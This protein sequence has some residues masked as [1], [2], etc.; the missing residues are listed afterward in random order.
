MAQQSKIPKANVYKATALIK[1][2][3]I[4]ITSNRIELKS[5]DFIFLSCYN[6]WKTNEIKNIK[7]IQNIKGIAKIKDAINEHIQALFTWIKFYPELKYFELKTIDEIHKLNSI[8]V[9]TPHIIKNV[10]LSNA[11]DHYKYR[12]VPKGNKKVI[13]K[14]I[15]A[16]AI[17][18]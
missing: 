5:F 9:I 17:Y 16:A 8:I 14:N 7:T 15:R 1:K 13:L 4:L 18:F 11:I 2:L 6:P 3:F 12:R 10:L